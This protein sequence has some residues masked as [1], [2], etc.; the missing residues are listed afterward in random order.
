MVLAQIVC[1][2]FL[3]DKAY[4]PYTV[5]MSKCESAFVGFR[6]CAVVFRTGRA[7]QTV[8]CLVTWCSDSA[9]VLA[10]F[11]A[12]K[13]GEPVTQQTHTKSQKGHSFQ[14]SSFKTCLYNQWRISFSIH[15][16]CMCMLLDS[17]SFLPSHLF[18][19]WP[20]ISHCSVCCFMHKLRLRFCE[21]KAA[22]LI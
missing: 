3:N 7:V 9:A 10:A 22:Y 2:L 8:E 16:S 6:V 15:H 20:R 12:G 13:P 5:Y 1:S 21:R 4:Q 18:Q 19:V 17:R 11:R 14:G